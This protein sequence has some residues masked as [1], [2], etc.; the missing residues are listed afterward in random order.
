MNGDCF[1]PS[2]GADALVGL[3][4]D[5]H[6]VDGDPERTRDVGAHRVD[7]WRKLRTLG[8]DRRVD[9]A[10]FEAPLADDRGGAP[11]QVDARR[12]LPLRIGATSM[13]RFG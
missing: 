1:T 2:K 5:A 4:F 12:V 13:A 11:Q 9:V 8:D 7:K 10:D 6:A 3:A